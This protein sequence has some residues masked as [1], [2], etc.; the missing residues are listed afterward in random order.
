V[1]V[2]I[3]LLALFLINFNQFAQIDTTSLAYFC[4]LYQKLEATIKLGTL[5]TFSQLGLP[6]NSTQAINNQITVSSG[7]SNDIYTIVPSAFS[8]VGGMALLQMLNTL[9]LYINNYLQSG[10]SATKNSLNLLTQIVPSF[11]SYI[12]GLISVNSSQIASNSS[13]GIL[14]IIVFS[15]VVA[16]FIVLLWGVEYRLSQ[17]RN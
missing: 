3:G 15:V 12:D 7:L 9:N 6:Q 14:V 8:E 13:L 5:T 2:S 11:Y 16:V 1:L 4:K 10:A 17:Q